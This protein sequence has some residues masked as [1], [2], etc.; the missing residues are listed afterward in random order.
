MLH[1]LN[2]NIANILSVLTSYSK[3]D[4]RPKLAENNLEGLIKELEKGVNILGE[5]ITETLVE[6]KR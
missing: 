5:V 1:T 3:L 4:F 6:N 2:T